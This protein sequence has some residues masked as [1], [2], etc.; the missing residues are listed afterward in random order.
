VQERAGLVGGP[1]ALPGRVARNPTLNLHTGS[2]IDL[3]LDDHL[4]R[5]LAGSDNSERY[6]SAF[7]IAL[8][9]VQ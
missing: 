5:R 6:F 4:R 2:A 1:K 7:R 8:D 3:D 9:A